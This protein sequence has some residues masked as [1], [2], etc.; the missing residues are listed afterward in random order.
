MNTILQL[1]TMLLI[2]GLGYAIATFGVKL[3]TW[4]HNRRNL[5]MTIVS[6]APIGGGTLLIMLALL[7]TLSMIIN[8]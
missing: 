6:Y 8:R 2:A 3:F 5:F 1:I 4:A 7:T